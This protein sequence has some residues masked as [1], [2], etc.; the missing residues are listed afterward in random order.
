MRDFTAV[1]PRLWHS[2]RFQALPDCDARLAFLYLL[3]GPHQTCAGYSR[4]PDEYGAGDLGWDVARYQKAQRAIVDSGLVIA[5]DST[6]ELFID[7]WFPF[8][9]AL[10]QKN[11]VGIDKILARIHSPSIV[12]EISRQLEADIL[13]RTDREREESER[14]AKRVTG[15]IYDGANTRI[16]Q[17]R[18]VH[19]AFAR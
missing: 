12:D 4:V 9:G 7:G 2:R 18:I 13:R 14:K 16:A 5:D 15:T 19:G 6:S 11:Q 1:S 8:S 3:S 17:S 10:G